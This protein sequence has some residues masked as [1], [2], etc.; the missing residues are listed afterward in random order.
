MECEHRHE[1]TWVK[2]MESTIKAFGHR[3]WVVIADSAFPMLSSTGITTLVTDSDHIDVLR[4]V[5]ECINSH[6][7][8]RPVIHLDAEL[9]HVEEQDAPGIITLR[10]QLNQLLNGLDVRREPHMELI[11]RMNDTSNMFQILVLKTNITLPYTTIFIELDCG[12]WDETRESQLRQRM[13][14]L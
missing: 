12:Y 9:Q 5:L 2:Q 6:S 8:I 1:I 3:N 14:Q 10:Q 4:G 7:H 13:G 11:R